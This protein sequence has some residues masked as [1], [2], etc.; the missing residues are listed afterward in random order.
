MQRCFAYSIYVFVLFVSAFALSIHAQSDSSTYSDSK[1]LQPVQL[2]HTVQFDE[3][4]LS[5]IENDPVIV[6]GF[7]RVRLEGA[8][9]MNVPGRP[10]LPEKTLRIALPPAAT[11]VGVLVDH[12]ES[13]V[14]EGQYSIFP[15][16][17]PRPKTDL[18]AHPGFASPEPGIYLSEKPFPSEPV[19][20]VRQYDLAGQNIAV[21]RICPFE[22]RPALQRLSFMTSIQFSVNCENGF[23]V[24]DFL[25]ERVSAEG[26]AA[27][28]KAIKQSVIN[29]SDVRLVS[30]PAKSMNGGKASQAGRGVPPGQYD[31]VIITSDA[32][33]TTF[34]RLADWRI[35]TG[36]P[37]EIVT[38]TWI[39]TQGGYTGS[40]LEK[41]RAF[42]V[43]AH[44]TWGTR[45]FLLGGDSNTI[46]Y[47]TQTITVPGY[48]TSD[49]NND[50]FLAD[51][52]D[53]WA[54]EVEIGR[55][56]VRTTATIDVMIDKI[57]LY[58]KNPPS[59]DYLT[60]AAYFGFDITTVGD[61]DGEI[62]KEMIRS[63]HMPTE[64]TLDTEYDSEP[65][66][67]KADVVAY[68]ND[69]YHLVNHHDHCDQT[70]LGTGWISHGELFTVGDA[71]A[72]RNGD[73]QSLVFA[74]GC[75]PADFTYHKS[76]GEALVRNSKGGAVAF[77]GN[78]CIGWGGP[79]SDP[80][81][82]SVRQDRYFYR[83]LFDD[84]FERLGANFMD[85]KNDEYDN[86]D[87]YNLHKYCFTQM[88]L[89]GD[90]ELVVWT[91]EPGTLQVFHN[92]AVRAG[93]SAVIAVSV[94]DGGSAIEGARVCLWKDGDVYE[95]A[96]T[97][98]LGEVSFNITPS[99]AGEIEVT[100]TKHNYLP[101]ESKAYVV[102][103][104][105]LNTDRAWI[106]ESTGAVVNFSLDATVANAG[107]KYLLLGSGTGTSP[108]FPLPGGHVV[109]PLNWD[110][111]TDI[112]VSLVNTALF[113]GFLG[114]LDPSGQSTAQI[115]CPPLPSGYAGFVMN[116][117][118]CLNNPFDAVS[119]PVEVVIVP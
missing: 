110:V 17:Y 86:N 53:D 102:E 91:D 75:Y 6:E 60:R 9:Y 8:E 45:S 41:I 74:I 42:I 106:S 54:C 117:A 71:D 116:Y 85:L 35:Q 10:M 94:T 52:D 31:H 98:T 27:Y 97:D 26:Y 12:V 109:L 105:M 118:Y 88:T 25:P 66:L 14:L 69:G 33:V 36:V 101:T 4:Q 19:R 23:E 5:L 29:P 18:F 114:I 70:C 82:Y 7:T 83:N 61:M 81:W 13:T 112:V 111:F 107:R 77:M 76:V 44:A 22:Y 95:V 84:G 90:P 15:A 20:F 37:T 3:G 51:F 58:E 57:L 80:D 21:F 59:T 119:N 89:L 113:P 92:Q 64:W 67:H 30:K 28:E 79:T 43:D 49:I 47:H 78:T 2:E 72:L 104:C 96:H 46:P 34:Q 73:R 48:F 108:G 68:M 38:T 40:N 55:L 65:G 87:P 99:S 1:K 24:N 11:V 56:S 93:E 39:Y 16:Q 32:W 100:V 63:Q 115:V 62:C 50:T 103:T